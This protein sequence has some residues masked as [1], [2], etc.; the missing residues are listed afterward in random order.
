[1]DHKLEPVDEKLGIAL[2]LFPTARELIFS[3][4]GDRQLLNGS[5]YYWTGINR[6]M[7]WDHVHI[8]MANG[9]L[10]N[11][12]M[13][14]M[15][16]D[17]PGGRELVTPLDQAQAQL[18]RVALQAVAQSGGGVSRLDDHTIDALGKTFARELGSMLGVYTTREINDA[19]MTARGV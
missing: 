4:A 5:P 11:G 3:P 19:L 16:G 7:H 14:A 9:G 2:A 12:P 10:T 6:D 15:I 8:A 1:M 18:E 13:L 17:N